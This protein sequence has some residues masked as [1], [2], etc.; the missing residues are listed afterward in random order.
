MRSKSFK[1]N[2][3]FLAQATVDGDA[4]CRAG[5]DELGAG[6]MGVIESSLLAGISKVPARPAAA[7][8]SRPMNVFCGT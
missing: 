4:L 5:D 3:R 8:P 2:A 7:M 1:D 6:L